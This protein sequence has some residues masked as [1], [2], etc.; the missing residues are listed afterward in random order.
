MN[1][2]VLG[3]GFQTKPLE[4]EGLLYFV[5]KNHRRFCS[6]A[7]SAQQYVGRRGCRN[8]ILSV[9]ALNQ[10]DDSARHPRPAALLGVHHECAARDVLRP[11]VA[12]REVG[13][14][15][16][17]GGRARGRC[18]QRAEVVVLLKA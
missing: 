13:R 10:S 11:A 17:H 6:H 16:G 14:G 9:N 2:F 5:H 7:L 8:F 18:L 1:Y 12:E 4:L 15:A 3:L